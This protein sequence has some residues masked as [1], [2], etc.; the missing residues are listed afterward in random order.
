MTRSR[1]PTCGHSHDATA[2]YEPTPSLLPS[3]LDQPPDDRLMAALAEFAKELNSLPNPVEG[4]VAGLSADD[5]T[6]L[7]SRAPLGKRKAALRAIGIPV[8]PRVVGQ[9]LCQD[10]LT[11]L[12]RVHLDDVYHFSYA[13][14]GPAV[15]YLVTQARLANTA[16]EEP[17]SAGAGSRSADILRLAFWGSALRQPVRRPSPGLGCYPVLVPA[18]DPG[19][20]GLRRRAHDGQCGHRG[21]PGS[22]RPPRR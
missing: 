7:L 16:A 17:G 13:L 18:G 22:R 15:E 10:V 11:R 1:K 5:I 19:G 3:P 21:D 20:R 4:A 6:A 2:Y 8:A 9:A 12:A 14:T